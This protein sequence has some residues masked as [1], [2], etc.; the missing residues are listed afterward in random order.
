M[1]PIKITNHVL[2]QLGE[3]YGVSADKHG[4]QAA[5]ARARPIYTTSAGQVYALAAPLAFV[6]VRDRVAVT[7]LS[8]EQ[9]FADCPRAV[10]ACMIRFGR[11]DAAFSYRARFSQGRLPSAQDP[12]SS[13]YPK[14]CDTIWCAF[15]YL[16]AH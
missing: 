10:F 16:E 13:R 15:K 6:V 14:A 8:W 3:R 5:L 11:L 2:V 4:L 9:A 1:T 12:M 7:A